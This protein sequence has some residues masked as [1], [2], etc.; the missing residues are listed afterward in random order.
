M[1]TTFKEQ[2]MGTKRKGRG[3]GGRCHEYATKLLLHS[4]MREAAI[5]IGRWSD[6]EHFEDLAEVYLDYIEQCSDIS[7]E[8]VIVHGYPEAGEQHLNGGHSWVEL[9]GELVL[10]PSMKPCLVQDKESF[11]KNGMIPTDTTMRFTKQQAKLK[12]KST[13]KYGGEFWR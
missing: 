1:T 5:A 11:Y 7:C 13:S 10:D 4:E 6:Y 8:A 12:I 3:G 9:N 2:T